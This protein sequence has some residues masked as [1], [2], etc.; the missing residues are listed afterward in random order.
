MTQFQINKY[1]SLKLE[2]GKTNIYVNGS[3]FH[4]CKF[5]L[6]QIPVKQMTLLSDMGS[7]DEV[8]DQL[9]KRLEQG[10]NVVSRIPPEV[11]FW[12]HCSNLQVW[13]E[14]GYNTSLLHSNLAFPL[15]KRLVDVGDQNAK[16]VFKEEII[17]R[18]ESG[19]Y[20]VIYYLIKEN[21]TTYIERQD[22]FYSI[23]VPEEAEIILKLER[24]LDIE[25]QI[26]FTKE[27]LEW[28]KSSISFQNKRVI[29]LQLVG[30]G[31]E[32]VPE[33]IKQLNV[34]KYLYLNGN[35]FKSL[36][37]WIGDYKDLEILSLRSC[38]LEQI[39]ESIG[40]LKRLNVLNLVNNYLTELPISIGNLANLKELNCG[41]NE[42][43]RLPK[44]IG[45]L[46]NLEELYLNENVIKELPDTLGNLSN[47]KNLILTL[48][49]LQF[50]P[51]TIRFL[52]N[53][54]SL[55]IDGNYF[56][57]LPSFLLEL[58]NLKKVAINTNLMKTISDD[59]KKQLDS[60]H[61]YIE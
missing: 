31:L 61:I 50:F 43:I 49:K 53:L 8:A 36:P 26:D 22:L 32:S 19:Y 6:L 58:P 42:L 20:P 7:I 10:V 52:I 14:N 47:L 11:E 5:L 60:R 51:E 16:D 3:L 33:S 28:V 30:H 34:L 12:G 55:K 24:N 40:N 48:N 27:N 18:L 56:K 17:R 44:S 37:E 21:Y 57:S 39:P 4:Q 15:L 25:F 29:R 2:N 45:S 46:K 23:L 35:D 9:D 59:M 13:Y 41:N 1:L 54:E 38:D